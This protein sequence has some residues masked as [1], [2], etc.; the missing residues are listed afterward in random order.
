MNRIYTFFEST[1]H[2]DAGGVG[3]QRGSHNGSEHPGSSPA[4]TDSPSAADAP[5][6]SHR[7]CRTRH[8]HLKNPL[9]PQK[10]LFPRR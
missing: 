5:P 7:Q 8:R 9:P 4:D 3:F 6:S 1:E 2:P 10:P